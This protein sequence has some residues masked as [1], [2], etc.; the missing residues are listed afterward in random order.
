MRKADFKAKIKKI[1]IANRTL[2]DT[3]EQAI[4]VQLGEIELTN[5]NLLE[6]KQFRPNEPVQVIITPLQVTLADKGISDDQE[7]G[8]ED[9]PPAFELVEGETPQPPGA[10][11][12][13]WNF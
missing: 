2:S 10:V 9:E 3:W 12:K 7:R 11:Y 1:E 5:E 13:A 8:F 6:L 4:R